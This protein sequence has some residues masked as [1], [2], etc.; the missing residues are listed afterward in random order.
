MCMTVALR[1][2]VL[3]GAGTFLAGL[4]GPDCGAAEVKGAVG[5]AMVRH[6]VEERDASGKSLLAE[7]GWQ[8][9]ISGRSEIALPLGF[10]G[11]SASWSGGTLEYDGI[12]QRG[13]AL[14]TTTD[15][16][17]IRAGL[18][19]RVPMDVSSDFRMRWEY[20]KRKRSIRPTG[21]LA[22]LDEVYK[23]Q[24]VAG[25]VV[26]RPA[27]LS[28]LTIAAEGLVSVFALQT[29]S[30]DGV[31]DPVDI[32]G[33]AV[34]GLALEFSQAMSKR[35]WAATPSWET[36][37]EYLHAARSNSRS[38]TGPAGLAGSLTQPESTRWQLSSGF[39]WS[40]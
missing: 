23:T 18:H 36:R 9:G 17:L 25:G 26:W 8:P 39:L 13:Q 2:I 1:S 28:G 20:E 5:L 37:L 3:M 27:R 22:G 34:R 4:W 10:V 7:N 19:Y 38:F 40:W 32:P 33:K 29:V 30:A 6:R 24:F 11:A 12:T 14:A 15:Q 31:I 16:Y 21:S 35:F